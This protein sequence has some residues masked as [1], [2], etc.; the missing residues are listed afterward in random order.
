MTRAPLLPSLLPPLLAMLAL[1]AACTAAPPTPEQR[2]AQCEADRTRRGIGRL[3][4]PEARQRPDCL[5][6]AD[7]TA[8]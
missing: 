6:P 1:L 5:P 2:R 4:P 8:R 3:L 7:P